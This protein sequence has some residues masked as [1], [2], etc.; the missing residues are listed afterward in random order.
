MQRSLIPLFLLLFCVGC[1]IVAPPSLVKTP[2]PESSWNEKLR[3]QAATLPI[4][5][6]TISAESLTIAYPQ[7]SLFATGAVLPLAGG[8]EALDPLAALLR[9]YP[10]ASWDARVRAATGN[11]ADY[12]LTLAQKRQELL[13]RYLRNA[14]VAAARVIWQADS[15]D[16]IPLEL[17]LRP[18][19]PLPESSSGVKE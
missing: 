5:R 3:Q 18:P 8:A 2:A 19:Q 11:G 16:G 6:V 15:G 13:Q 17:I 9:S 4:A 12:D 7:E 10:E 1:Q 14:G